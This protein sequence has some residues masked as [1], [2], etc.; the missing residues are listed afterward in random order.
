M[1]KMKSIGL[2]AAELFVTQKVQRFFDVKSIIDEKDNFSE[3][4][5]VERKDG[6]KIPV[7]VSYSNIFDKNKKIIGRMASFIDLSEEYRAKKRLKLATNRVQVLTSKL[8]ESEE[9]QKKLIAK[10]LHDGIGSNLNSD[11]IRFNKNLYTVFKGDSSDTESL[12]QV[13][14]MVRDTIDEV[15]RVSYNLRPAVLDDVCGE[16]PG[17]WLYL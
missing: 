1:K 16:Y 4:F 14:A 9:K 5:I 6:N 11:K 2:D 17:D 10:E 13:I 8:V 3:E 15:H 12:N 7:Q